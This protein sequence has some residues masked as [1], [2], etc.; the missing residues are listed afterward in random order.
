MKE[1]VTIRKS[2]LERIG[3]KL[4]KEINNFLHD[5]YI[6]SE[7]PELNNDRENF[8]NRLNRLKTIHETTNSEEIINNLDIEEICHF[9]LQIKLDSEIEEDLYFEK[10]SYLDAFRVLFNG[11]FD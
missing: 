2:D 11:Y 9:L 8:D 4:M 7:F 6:V 5:G 1:S 10:E 3:K